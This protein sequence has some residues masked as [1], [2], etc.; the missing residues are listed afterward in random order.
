M[1]EKKETSTLARFLMTTACFVVVI[2]GLNASQEFVVPFL[3]S[4]MVAALTA[5]PLFWLKSKGVPSWAALAV[6]LLVVVIG[7]VAVA[8]VIGSSASGFMEKKGAYGNELQEKLDMLYAGFDSM[9]WEKPEKV[10]GEQLDPSRVM[11]FFAASIKT[12][13]GVLANAF[14]ILLTVLF[15]LLEAATFS[16]KLQAAFGPGQGT[17][18]PFEEFLKS[19]NRYL[20]IKTG[21]S[22]LTGVLAG[23]FLAIMGVPFAALWGLVAF[24]LNYIPTIGSILAAIPAVLL[25]LVELGT[26][27]AVGVGI[28]Y[29]V[30]NVGVGNVLEP[31]LMGRGLGLS[32]LVIFISL[33]FW[34]SVL[35]VGGALLSVPL[36]VAVKIA[37]SVRE[38]TRW[39]AVLMGSGAGARR[40]ASSP[41]VE[42]KVEGKAEGSSG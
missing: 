1:S 5:P 2:W 34:G 4:V 24:L 29:V 20:V 27:G 6:V 16:G 21:M 25:A 28:G 19:I 17:L 36:T 8:T 13:T 23:I 38:D 30:L 37:L 7:V 11:A 26:D 40:V 3:L 33:A 14:L 22:A 10:I 41:A 18:G 32:A 42:E 15:I 39:L 31:R 12:M 9:G 35:G